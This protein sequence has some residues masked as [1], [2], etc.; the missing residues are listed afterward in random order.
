ME[1]EVVLC[2]FCHPVGLMAV[3]LL[4]FSD[5]LEILMIC[6]DLKILSCSH[7]VVLPLIECKH[8]CEQFFVV[9]FVISFC[10]CE[11][12][13]QKGDWVPFAILFLG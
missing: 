7:Q 4:G 13:R 12:L 10:N 9:N 6:P 3:Q 2:Q 1:R 5:I 11:G 8:N